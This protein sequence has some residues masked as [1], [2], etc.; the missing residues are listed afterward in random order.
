MVLE[1]V[2]V[3]GSGIMG[4][5]IA[6]SCALGGCRVRV[7]VRNR[8]K[9][10]R[11]RS[12]AEEHLEVLKAEEYVDDATAADALGRIELVNDLAGAVG[13]AQLIIEAIAENLEAKQDLFRQVEELAPPDALITSNS[14]TFPI[15]QINGR[16][17]SRERTYGFHW[18][19]PAHLVPLVE[20][21]PWDGAS[22][23][24]VERL[25]QFA[26]EIGKAPVVCKESP[27]FVGVR[28]QAALVTEAVRILQ[29][30]LATA[31]DIDTAVR[32]SFGLR[33]PLFGPLSVVDFGGLDT[34]LYAYQFL[35]RALGE[36]FQPAQV[37]HDLVAEGKLG[38]KTGRGFYD[39][40]GQDLAALARER[41]R[42]L[43]A[44]LKHLG[45]GVMGD[46]ARAGGKGA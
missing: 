26:R 16:M 24:G 35:A 15:S 37:L 32:L 13:D 23:E 42:R 25:R 29:E 33:L 43:I 10:E 45:W 27:G 31:E 34:F 8:A 18:Y 44:L 17:R 38:V 41:D 5:T 21:I 9:L 12:T 14:S 11:V 7:W 4:S 1:R 28:L 40:T 36:R 39:Y 2:A 20:I 3:V 6:L 46:V 19:N 22:P 30:G